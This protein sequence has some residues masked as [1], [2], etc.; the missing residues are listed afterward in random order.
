MIR[1]Q[2]PITHPCV[3][4]KNHGS[5]VPLLTEAHHILPL[6]AGGPDTL[7]N[8]VDVCATGHYNVHRL[9]GLMVFLQPLPTRHNRKEMAMALKGVRLWNEAGKP[10]SPASF[11][12]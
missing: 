12:G 2:D 1:A 10:G 3:L 8:K 4:H 7:E 9:M 11:W 6:G 5:A